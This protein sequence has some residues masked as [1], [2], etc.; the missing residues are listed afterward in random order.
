MFYTAT[1]IEERLY[2]WHSGR[3]KYLQNLP[4]PLGSKTFINFLSLSVSL[5]RPAK[6]L[7][8]EFYDQSWLF[9]DSINM[10]SSHV[11]PIYHGDDICYICQ[12]IYLNILSEHKCISIILQSTICY[13]KKDCWV[14]TYFHPSF[15]K[16][17]T[18]SVLEYLSSVSSFF[19]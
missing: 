5:S 14:N 9:S 3:V 2:Q 6:R 4:F 7:T 12:S 8:E 11:V 13:I 15:F 1:L 18:I 16:F 19:N 17:N 10:M